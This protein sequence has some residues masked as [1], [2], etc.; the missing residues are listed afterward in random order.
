MEEI[1]PT[2]MVSA[3]VLDSMH[4]LDGGTCSDFLERIIEPTTIRT[5]PGCMSPGGLLIVNSRIEQIQKTWIKDFAR[6]LRFKN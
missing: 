5:G 4:T 3:F 1:F 2:R 6:K